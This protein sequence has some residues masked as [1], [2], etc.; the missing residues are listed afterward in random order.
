M[1]YEKPPTSLPF[2]RFTRIFT[3]N[4]VFCIENMVAYDE[5]GVLPVSMCEVIGRR[6]CLDQAFKVNL[7]FEYVKLPT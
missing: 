6:I 5:L 7:S 4:A 1:I 2:F 3:A